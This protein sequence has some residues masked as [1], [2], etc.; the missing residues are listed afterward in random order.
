MMRRVNCPVNGNVYIVFD[1]SSVYEDEC[2]TVY[3]EP[4]HPCFYYLAVNTYNIG[5]YG[6]TSDVTIVGGFMVNG[7]LVQQ[8][9]TLLR[10][11]NYPPDKPQEQYGNWV[12]QQ[13]VAIYMPLK[14]KVYDT[15]GRHVESPTY[16]NFSSG[17]PHFLDIGQQFEKVNFKNPSPPKL[18]KRQKT[19]PWR[20]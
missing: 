1:T 6:G 4:P 3:G 11:L 20:T 13:N 16:N 7:T 12:N 8:E 18:V 14:F 17:I 19:M 2:P 9:R 10:N 5:G 15:M